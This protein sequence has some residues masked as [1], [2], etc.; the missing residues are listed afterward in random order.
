MKL[1]WNVIRNNKMCLVYSWQHWFWITAI[2]III[3]LTSVVTPHPLSSYETLSSSLKSAALIQS[4]ENSFQKT[5]NQ[6]KTQLTSGIKSVPLTSETSDTD[7][8]FGGASELNAEI[9]AKNKDW[10]NIPSTTTT[11]K[12]DT[13]TTTTMKSLRNVEHNEV[14]TIVA[15]LSLPNVNSSTKNLTI[16]TSTIAT[17]I[18]TT[19]TESIDNSRYEKNILNRFLP[20]LLLLLSR[21]DLCFIFLSNNTHKKSV[22]LSLFFV[23]FHMNDFRYLFN[24]QM[25][26][27]TITPSTTKLIKVE[28]SSPESKQQQQQQILNVQTVNFTSDTIEPYSNDYNDTVEIIMTDDVNATDISDF[29]N[30]ERKSKGLIGFSEE[31]KFVNNISSRSTLQVSHDSEMI[32]GGD[33]DLSSEALFDMDEDNGGIAMS[34][35]LISVI[36]VGVIGSLSAFSIMFVYVYRQRFLN[37]PQTLSEPDSSGYIDDSSIRV[38]SSQKK[39]ETVNQ[40]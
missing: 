9:T 1:K 36:C 31:A 34:A 29:T 5:N 13:T 39:E 11:M 40:Y 24:S 33:D 2:I 4:N 16:T 26:T 38:S 10:L 25:K 21:I 30:T 15:A 18:L 22:S 37:K 23:C 28:E 3:A 6:D 7:D 12:I 19:V 8:T 20:S 14:P 32:V 17:T 35:G 27:S